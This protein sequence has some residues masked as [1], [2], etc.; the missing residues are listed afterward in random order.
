MILIYVSN[1][2]IGEVANMFDEHVGYR[3]PRYFDKPERCDKVYIHGDYPEIAEAYKGK[4][5]EAKQK[6]SDY[7]IAELRDMKSDI[8]D[9]DSFITGDKRKSVA[10]I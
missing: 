1:K 6:S 7:T 10:S 9:W 8:E 5:I 4:V 2:K 3:N